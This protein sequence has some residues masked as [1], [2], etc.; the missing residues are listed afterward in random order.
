MSP[1]TP[2][3]RFAV[4]GAGGFL[5]SH[6]VPALRQRFGAEVEAV[7]LDLSKLE[8]GDAGIT[9]RVASIDEPGLLQ[10]VVERSD[11]VISLT[12]ICNPSVYNQRPLDVIDANYTDLIPLVK[13]CTRADAGWCIFPP[14]RSTAR[15]RWPPPMAGRCQR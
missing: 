12:A 8:R 4:L 7:D 5:G 3:R 1:A 15:P 14:A 6:L 2:P 10:D 13:L 11:V 9:R